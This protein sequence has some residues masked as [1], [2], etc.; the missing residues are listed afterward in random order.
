MPIC[1]LS[2]G[3]AAQ[4]VVG[5]GTGALALVTWRLAGRTGEEVDVSRQG[6]ELTRESIEALDLPFL[7]A[8]FDLDY[9]NLGLSPVFEGDSEVPVDAE[10][11]VGMKV[12]NV[13]RGP[14]ILFGAI[15]FSDDSGEEPDDRW[16]TELPIKAGEVIELSVRTTVE[17]DPGRK[18][19]LILR[20]RSASGASYVTRHRVR[21]QKGGRTSRLDIRREAA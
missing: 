20:Y 13:G 15:A 7:V 14:A 4:L 16:A 2:V 9:P 21:V 12:E 17:P 6:L 3:D 1:A 19:M 11:T 10:W 8:S 5:V 18:L